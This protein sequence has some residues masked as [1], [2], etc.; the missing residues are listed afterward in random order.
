MYSTLRAVSVFL[1]AARRAAR[2]STA[3]HLLSTGLCQ[4]LVDSVHLLLLSSLLLDRLSIPRFLQRF[5][6]FLQGLFL[7]SL[8]VFMSLALCDLVTAKR[9]ARLFVM[10]NT[11]RASNNPKL[12]IL[13]SVIVLRGNGV[14]HRG[15]KPASRG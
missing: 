7:F 10:P 3:S 12:C 6:L 4:V 11:P 1:L 15:Q 5:E 8:P 2:R 14:I 9:R 13:Y